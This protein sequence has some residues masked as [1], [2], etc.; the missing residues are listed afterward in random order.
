L[1][2]WSRWR[3]DW[4]RL[5]QA[6][7]AASGVIEPAVD[8]TEEP[9]PVCNAQCIDFVASVL[10]AADVAGRDVLEV[11]ALDVNGTVRPVVEALGPSSYIGVDLEEGPGVDEVLSA[12]N[13][14]ERFGP[15]AFDV[16]I[17]TE[18]LEHV[19]DWRLVIRNLKLVTR[20]G[21]LVVVTTRSRGFPLHGYPWD[22]WRYEPEDMAVIFADCPGVRVERDVATDPGVF[23]MAR[24]PLE[25]GWEPL[26]LAG[27]A[28]WSVHTDRRTL[29]AEDGPPGPHPLEAEVARLE[30]EVA[31][32][33]RREASVRA[34]ADRR[35]AELQATRTMR[36]TAGARSVYGRARRLARLS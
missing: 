27:Y 19:R 21:G 1:R 24:R 11:G 29:D 16:V 7:P 3:R 18:L 13:L 17:T 20:P 33:A 9:S 30:A 10:T 25:E 22:H 8:P 35:V 15:G 31:E 12:E 32:G 28:L 36:W 26:D 2:C 14:V 34:E 4:P 6:P 5:L 23:V